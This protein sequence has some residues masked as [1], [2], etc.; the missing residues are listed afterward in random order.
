VA[1]DAHGAARPSRDP[2]RRC[3][4]P[5]THLYLGP[6]SSSSC[7]GFGRGFGGL[8]G[9]SFFAAAGRAPVPPRAAPP[10]APLPPLPAQSGRGVASSALKSA[11]DIGVALLHGLLPDMVAR[12]A[13]GARLGPE[14]ADLA[15]YRG[16]M[17]C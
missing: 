8:K 14:S 16:R 2:F 10:L 15:R 9:L 17:W 1:R 3:A 11:L 5:R 12:G 4:G 6:S 7:C 13:G